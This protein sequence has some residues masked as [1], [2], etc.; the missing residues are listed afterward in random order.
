MRFDPAGCPIFVISR[1][2]LSPLRALV[3]WLEL[4]GHERIIVVDNASTYEPLL[5]YF[6]DFSHQLIRLDANVGPRA[7]WDCELLIRIGH[8]GPFVVTDADVIPDETCPLDAVDHFAELLFRYSDVDKVGFGLRIDDL[9]A[10]YQFRHEAIDWER[11]F[12]VDELEPGVFRAD[13]DTTFALYRPR[14]GR[15]TLRALRTGAPYVARHLGWYGDS[16]HL[17][18]EEQYYRDHAQPGVSNWDVDAL[19]QVLIEAIEGHRRSQLGDSGGA[20]RP[21]DEASAIEQME[22]RLDDEHAGRV[23]A[24]GELAAIRSSRSYRYTAPL[25]VARSW[26]ARRG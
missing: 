25:R 21:A 16:Q 4:A 18:E 5:D 11:Q 14:T 12:W 17:T 2:R 13:I 26:I 24:E 20:Q 8:D 15:E 23:A 3:S 19:P 22:H 9:P 10:S 6:T 1:D 7:V